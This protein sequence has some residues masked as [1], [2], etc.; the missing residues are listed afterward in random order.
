MSER[1]Y[2]LAYLH[3]Y[4]IIQEGLTHTVHCKFTDRPLTVLSIET[5]NGDG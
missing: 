4:I 1:S 5:L 2:Y 3:C